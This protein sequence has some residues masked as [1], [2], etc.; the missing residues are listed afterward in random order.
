MSRRV[1]IVGLGYAGFR[2]TS[3]DVSYREMIFEAATKC[4]EDAGGIHPQEIDSFVASAEDFMEG[5]SIADEYVPDQL[6]AVLKPVQ[7]IAGDGLQGLAS[8]VMQIKTSKLDLVAVSAFSKVSNL[9]HYEHVA[10]YASDPAYIRPLQENPDFI[11]GLEMNRY[12]YETETSR[13]QCAAVV[14]KNKYNAL[15]NPLAA[16]GAKTS[17]DDIINAPDLSSP[18]K[19]YDKSGHLDGAIVLLLAPEERVAEFTAKPVWVKGIGW[20]TDT[21]NL[22]SRLK[23]FGSAVYAKL[24]GQMAYKMAGI[25]TPYKELDFAE[26]DDTY[27]YKELQHLEALSLCSSGKA[28]K[29]LEMGC[30]DSTGDLPVNI[31][32][33]SLGVG[34]LHEANGLHRVLE[35][36]LQ[37]RNES[38]KNQLPAAETGLAFAWRGVPTATGAAVILGRRP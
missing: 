30:F 33:G 12:L 26:I 37:L 21:P 11:A 3:A 4:Y 5:I 6:G 16:Y 20:A 17:I 29:L 1:A 24:A 15:N 34:Y 14:V 28:G 18:L 19:A 7:S 10:A 35:T 25:K 38:G 23:G 2:T 22:D 13:A 32:G 36:A 9:S 8:A 31:S 27:S